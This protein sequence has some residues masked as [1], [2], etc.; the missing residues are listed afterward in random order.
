MN[1][2]CL[3]LGMPIFFTTLVTFLQYALE[4][5]PYWCT[6]IPPIRVLVLPYPP[7]RT[8]PICLHLFAKANLLII[9]QLTRERKIPYRSP[10]AVFSSHDYFEKAKGLPFCQYF[11]LK[12]IYCVMR[13]CIK[14]GRSFTGN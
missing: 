11:Y 9:R 2:S 8:S 14:V 13:Y 3:N 10:A 4:D 6:R 7:R 12:Y 1:V 5:L